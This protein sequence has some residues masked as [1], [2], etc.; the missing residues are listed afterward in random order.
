MGNLVGMDR[1]LASNTE[2]PH[3]ASTGDTFS[4]RAKMGA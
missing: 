4:L 3:C 1:A 2:G